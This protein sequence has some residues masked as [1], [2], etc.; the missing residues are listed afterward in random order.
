M[1]ME[2]MRWLAHIAHVTYAQYER[3]TNRTSKSPVRDGLGRILTSWVRRLGDSVRVDSFGASGLSV[4][5]LGGHVE[6]R[7]GRRR[8]A[9]EGSVHWLSWTSTYYESWLVKLRL[10]SIAL[11]TLVHVQELLTW[12]R[13]KKYRMYVQDEAE[14][15]FRVSRGTIQFIT[16][17]ADFFFHRSTA[18][19][20]FDLIRCSRSLHNGLGVHLKGGGGE[21][22]ASNV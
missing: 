15:A 14:S 3:H 5:R 20:R 6:R 1:Y 12:G 9:R 7:H 10:L 2:K 11:M 8:Q 18:R 21:L 4:W 13:E 19:L 16:A 22:M 17:L